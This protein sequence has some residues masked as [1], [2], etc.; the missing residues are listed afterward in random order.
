MMKWINWWKKNVG[1]DE[2]LN[3]ELKLQSSLTP[4]GLRTEFVDG[5]RK[6]LL[7]QMPKIDLSVEYQSPKLQTGLLITGGA[8]GALAMVLTGVRGLIS[9]IGVVGLFVSM[10]KHHSQESSAPSNFAH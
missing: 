8:L 10:I 7:K 4:V 5:L 9:V 2:F 3:L 1:D 6:N